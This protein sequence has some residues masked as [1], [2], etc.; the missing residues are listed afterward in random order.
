MTALIGIVFFCFLIIGMP[1]AFCLGLTSLVS[2]VASTGD[3]ALFSML[4]QRLVAGIN[5]FPLMAIPFFILSGKILTHTGITESLVNFSESIVGHLRGGLAHVNIL[6]S[7]FFAGLSG[8]AVADTSALGS[9]LIPA[10]EKEGYSRSFSTAVTAASSVIGPIIPP[11]IL[12]IIY[13]YTMEVSVAGLFSAGFIPGFLMGLSLMIISYCISSKRG[14][15]KREKRSS[16]V[17][18]YFAF[19]KSI[20]AL[21]APIIILGGIL[22]GMATPTEAA[23]VGVGYALFLGAFV[24]RNLNFK[25]LYEIF[26]N[27]AIESAVVFLVIGFATVF[28]WLITTNQIP[29]L[30]AANLTLITSN[31]I[32]LLILLNILLFLV[33]MFLDAGPAVIIMAPILSGIAI[34]VIGLHPLHWAIIMCINLTIGLATP[35]VGMILFVACGMTGLKLD[36]LSVALLPFIGAE[37][38]VLLLITF[39]PSISMILPKLIGYY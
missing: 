19:K 24:L 21:L 30:L 1:I 37:F 32:M 15:P 36:K 23:A 26:V 3:T 31:K 7:I 20:L 8:S 33:G 11:S 27:A 6:A 38:A 16:I 13:A 29:Q 22:S 14:Y 35:P 28:S 25:N 17:E 18:I 12:M 5:Q 34:D 39:V 2:F 10:M 4:V 9:I